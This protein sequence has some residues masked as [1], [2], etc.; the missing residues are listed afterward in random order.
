VTQPG[1][2]AAV[3]TDPAEFAALRSEWDAT[4]EDS[5]QRVFFLRWQWNWSWWTHF[6]PSDARLHIICVRSHA[7]GLLGVAPF[8]CRQHRLWGAPTARELFFIGTGV[9]V[10]T[11]EYLDVFARRGAER[12]FIQAAA[13][14]LA[15]RPQWDR[16]SLIG[17]PAEASLGAELVSALSLRA[18]SEVCDEARYI[19]TSVSWLEYK[20]SLG[21]SMRRNVEYYSRRLFKNYTCE[22]HRVTSAAELDGAMTDLVRLHQARWRAIGEPGTLGLPGVESFLRETVRDSFAADRVRLWSL[23]VNGTVEAVLLGFCDNGVLHYFQKGFNPGY[24][25]DDLGTAMLGLCVKDCFDD[26]QIEAFDFMGGVAPYKAMWARQRRLMERREATRLNGRAACHLA[27]AQ[28]RELAARAYRTV[29]PQA[30]QRARR[31]RLR[32]RRLAGEAEPS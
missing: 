11:S 8:F 10:K 7:G 28:A 31:E 27:I 3:L 14:C 6:A 17:M 18:T 23:T 15:S 21:R 19:D 30:V 25:A 5:N 13:A 29:T 16:L 9:G 12:A 1:V 20:R 24:I 4:L 2:T 26:E 22:F 32:R